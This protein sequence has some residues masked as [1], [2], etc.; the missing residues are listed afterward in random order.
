MGTVEKVYNYGYSAQGYE[1]YTFIKYKNTSS[2]TE[3]IVSIDAYMGVAGNGVYYNTGDG[4]TGNGVPIDVTLFYGNSKATQSISKIV[5]RKTD[6]GGKTFYPDYDSSIKYTFVFNQRIEVKANTTISIYMKKPYNGSVLIY[7]HWNSSSER[8]CATVNTT[9]YSESYTVSFDA[10]GGELG[11]LPSFL[12]ATYANNY[13][14]SIIDQWPIRPGYQFTGWTTNAD[15]S[16]GV[17]WAGQTYGN[18]SSSFTLYARWK[19]QN[20]I[21]IYDGTIWR[22]AIPYIYDG[23]TWHETQVEIYNGSNWQKIGEELKVAN[24]DFS[25]SNNQLVYIT[26]TTYDNYKPVQKVANLD[27]DPMTIDNIIIGTEIIIEKQDE[28]SLMF[29]NDWDSEYV[30]LIEDSDHIRIKL[31]PASENKTVY[32]SYWFD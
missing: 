7:G 2:S 20:L 22:Q 16:G 13:T 26:Y 9:T 15:G 1:D 14:I 21:N 28:N 17:Y 19:P 25:D 5:G 10:N 23:A 18:I 4:V 31:L 24:I 30:E 11:T 27:I 3:W 32:V 29:L 12:T 8:F 6:D